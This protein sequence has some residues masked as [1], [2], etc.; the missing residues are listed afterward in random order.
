MKRRYI[1]GLGWEIRADVSEH[2]TG[3]MAMDLLVHYAQRK[4]DVC[5]SRHEERQAEEARRA[6]ARRERRAALPTPCM[7][8]T[9]A[10]TAQTKVGDVPSGPSPRVQGRFG[11]PRIYNCLA[12]NMRE[13][14]FRQCSRLDATPKAL[15]NK[16]HEERMAERLQEDQSRPKQTVAA[17][18]TSLGPP[19]SSS[20]DTSPPG[21]EAEELLPEDESSSENE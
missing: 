18:G 7:Y 20:G 13:H 4:N 19:W 12:S 16:A 6:K 14:F 2:S 9:A 17:V 5:R 10:V 15:L 8:V 1:Q 11:R 21:L 3:N